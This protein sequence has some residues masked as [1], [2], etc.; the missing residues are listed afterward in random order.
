[1]ISIQRLNAQ[2]KNKIGEAVVAYLMA[3]EYYVNGQ[4]AKEETTRWGGKL[5]KE[6]GLEGKEVSKEDMLQLARGYAPDGTALCKNAGEEP[7]EVVKTDRQGNPKLDAN[8]QPIKKLEGGHRVG[9][10]LT[11]SA[12]KPVS[13]AFAIAQG[14]ERDAILEAHRKAVAVGMQYLEEKVETRRGKAGKDVIQTQGVVFMQAD[15]LS[16]RNL[17]M[18]IH[19]HTLVFGVSKG[20]DGQWGT[21]DAA[22]LYSHRRTADTIYQNE[23]MLNMQALGYKVAIERE[24][25]DDGKETGLLKY[26][27][28]GI[29]QDL[30]D[31]FSTRRAELLE[32]QELHGVDAQTACLATRRHKDEPSY[33]EMTAMWSRLLE[34]FEGQVPTVEQ[35]KGEAANQFPERKTTQGVLER[36]HLSEAVFTDKDILHVLGQ[37]LAGQVRLD[38]LKAKADEFKQTA[39]LQHIQ[40]E[41]LADEDKGLTLAKRHTETRFAAPWMLDWEQEVVRRVEARKGEKHQSVPL[42]VVDRAIDEYQARKGFTLSD[43][44]RKAVVNLTHEEHGVG[45]LEGFAGTGKTTVSDCYAAAFKAQGRNLMGVCVSNA[46]AQKLEHES[47][48]PCMS[49]SRMLY[50]LDMGAREPEKGV[51]LTSRDVMVIDEAGMMDTDQTR[52]LLAYAQQAGAKVI[53]QGDEN[54]LQPVGAGS[55]LSLA[56]MAVEGTKLTEIRRQARQEDRDI[57][58]MFYQR[59]ASGAF[60]DVKKGER[61]KGDASAMGARILSALDKRGCLDDYEN[62]KDAMS[63]LVGDYLANPTDVRQKLV[64]GHSRQEVALLN[65]NIRNGLKTSGAVGAADVELEVKD[66]GKKARLLMAH[67]ERIRFTDTNR[68][69]GVVNGSEGVV[70]SIKPNDAKGGFDIAVRLESDIKNV[71]GRLVSF[72]TQDYNALAHNYATTVHKAQGAGKEH[73]YH[74]CNPSMMDNHSSLVAFTRLTKGDYRMY[75]TTD[76][77]ERLRDRFAL[78]R[79]KTTALGEGVQKPATMHIEQGSVAERLKAL[80]EHSAKHDQFL[81]R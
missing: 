53:L 81:A 57:A 34:D 75:G 71:N 21:F 78:E 15:H 41:K 66:Q 11:F 9:F 43:E 38:E 49:V 50:R 23:L 59:D 16:S 47:Q 39:G 7:R 17:D 63:A 28:A 5:A 64:L 29:G 74:L 2:G 26:E 14:E 31:R 25:N 55:G 80:Q 73:V 76:D 20:A 36:L 6:L 60:V 1:M 40:P 56:K 19:T 35:L 37:E 42:A 13:L 30:C 79:L 52:R 67:G 4:G 70:Q 48:M 69:L 44:Q 3:V 32:Y 61:S 24:V 27:I 18:N 8:G 33:T 22:E 51:R 65:E 58:Q 72:N 77:M 54:Q 68:Q 46:A 12:P 45:L 62:Q 10:D